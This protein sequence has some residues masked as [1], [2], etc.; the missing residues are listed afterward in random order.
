[1]KNKFKSS[2]ARCVCLVLVLGIAKVQALP[3]IDGIHPSDPAD[4][5]GG[6]DV[7]SHKVEIPGSMAQVTVPGK[8]VTK[9]DGDILKIV[10]PVGVQVHLMKVTGG[11]PW[12]VHFDSLPSVLRHQHPG[13]RL[14]QFSSGGMRGVRVDAPSEGR[15]QES[16]RSDD[17]QE[18]QLRSRIVLMS[19]Q[20]ALIK[21]DVSEPRST[22]KS[23]A[24]DLKEVPQIL[25]SVRIP[26]GGVP[27]TNQISR[28]V[29][30]FD[31]ARNENIDRSYYSFSGHCFY[32]FRDKSPKANTCSADSERK[33]SSIFQGSHFNVGTAGYDRGHIVDLGPNENGLMGK[34]YESV[35]VHDGKIKVLGKQVPV[36]NIYKLFET[37]DPSPETTRL[38]LKEGH[39]YLIRTIS[40]PDEDAIFKVHVQKINQTQSIVLTY[41]PLVSVDRSILQKWVDEM[42]RYTSLIEAPRTQGH[43]TLYN[44]A[45]YNSYPHAGF[46]IE[47]SSSG[48]HFYTN[49]HFDVLFEGDRLLVQLGALDRSIILDLGDRD[50]NSVSSQELEDLNPL[51]RSK[52]WNWKR[53]SRQASVVVGHTYFI[54]INDLHGNQAQ[55]LLRITGQGETFE[56]QKHMSAFKK[57]NIEFRR[58]KLGLAPRFFRD[59]TMADVLQSLNFMSD[60]SWRKVGGALFGESQKRLAYTP[61]SKAFEDYSGFRPPTYSVELK[62][63]KRYSDRDLVH[64]AFGD[65]RPYCA[66]GI[67]G[68][69]NLSQKNAHIYKMRLDPGV[70]EVKKWL[71]VAEIQELIAKRE[72]LLFEDE[73]QVQVGDLYLGRYEDYSM[74]IYFLIRLL[75][76]GFYDLKLIDQLL[77]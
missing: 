5:G 17:L 29:E 25:S 67:N 59:L 32:S 52:P 77:L 56:L 60:F 37:E 55:A 76:D 49:N 42:N 1:M 41:E 57:I 44:R 28:I 48:N 50:L 6:V 16:V 33:V 4:G 34:V 2:I 51:R 68:F 61:F 7:G 24:T 15:P 9:V 27:L 47:F 70:P 46:N 69:I 30:I 13:W 19:E 20:G 75:P 10:S 12:G 72:P 3:F 18:P 43:V 31:H 65:C 58:L 38:T 35:L 39:V 40:W 8:W 54:E 74:S 63:I 22:L 23:V 62:T 66:R 36:E 21:V 64:L 71:A 73:I 14:A 26:Y 11:S 45:F 53:S